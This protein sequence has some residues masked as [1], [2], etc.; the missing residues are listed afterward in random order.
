MKLLKEKNI[1][2]ILTVLVPV[3]NTEKYIEKC[4]LSLVNKKL[5][6]K[7]EVIIVSD[8]SKDKS[9][10]IAKKI[11]EENHGIFKI[12]EKENG[13]HGSTINVG[14]KEATG[15]YF[16]VLDSDDWFDENEFI[17]CESLSLEDIDTMVKN[18]EIVDSK[19]LIAIYAY[20]CS[21]T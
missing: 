15:K 3:Y 8:G 12:I 4:L 20:K 6:G 5:V 2:P 13:G 1:N 10:D 14:I 21:L 19:T 11:D 17:D 7:I 9:I 16:R 18:G